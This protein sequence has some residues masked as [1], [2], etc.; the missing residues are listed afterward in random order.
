M[1]PVLL[2]DL[3]VA[4]RGPGRPRARPDAL[5]A[6]KAYSARDHRALLRARRIRTVIPERADQQA[7]R[8]RRGSAGGR[9][10]A[11]DPD[12]Y[13]RR[14]VVERSYNQLKQWRGLATRYDKLALIFRG[15]AVLRSIIIWL[16][17]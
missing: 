16:S 11:F 17:P 15:G 13:K 2:G 1:L 9:P 12:T 10:P 3:R 14:N 6:D 5:I 4:R 7:N 8:A